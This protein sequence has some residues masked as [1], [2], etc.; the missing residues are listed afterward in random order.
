[1]NFPDDD[2]EYYT[3][4]ELADF[5][6][7]VDDESHPDGYPDELIPEHAFTNKEEATS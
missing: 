4:E 2:F 7:A 5:F 1:M 3:E 6:F